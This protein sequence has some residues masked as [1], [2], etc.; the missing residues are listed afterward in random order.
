MEIAS[1]ASVRQPVCRVLAPR[2]G[3]NC[4]DTP[5]RN[6]FQTEILVD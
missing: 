5:G 1:D 2:G 6:F 3:T 4:D